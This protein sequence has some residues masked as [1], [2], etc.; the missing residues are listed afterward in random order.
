MGAYNPSI[1]EKIE[2]PW[3]YW[4]ANITYLAIRDLVSNAVETRTELL[5]VTSKV[6]LWP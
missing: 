6:V 4:P 1:G 2:D 3:V 5:V